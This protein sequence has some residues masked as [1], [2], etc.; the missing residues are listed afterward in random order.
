MQRSADPFQK[1]AL[2]T[3]KFEPAFQGFDLVSRAE[4]RSF[5]V[6]FLVS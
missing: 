6:I 4:N 3:K 2:V 1:F 5:D